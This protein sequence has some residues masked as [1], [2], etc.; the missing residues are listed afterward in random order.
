MRTELIVVQWLLMLIGY[1]EFGQPISFVAFGGALALGL[2]GVA[3]MIRQWLSP[4]FTEQDMTALYDGVNGGILR[5]MR[6]VFEHIAEGRGWTKGRFEAWA[7]NR[8][9]R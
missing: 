9:W 1:A 2:F 4:D 3:N 6:P 8:V 5:P 7:K